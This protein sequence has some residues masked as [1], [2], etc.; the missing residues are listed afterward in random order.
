MKINYNDKRWLSIRIKAIKRDNFTCSNCTSTQNLQC[1]HTYYIPYRE[2]WEY[3]LQ[4]FQTLCVNC[5]SEYHRQVKGKDLVIRSNRLINLKLKE[6]RAIGFI[7]NKTK[8]TKVKKITKSKKPIIKKINETDRRIN[9][10]T[11]SLNKEEKKLQKRY[12]QVLRK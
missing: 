1:H 11:K 2:I 8:H 5:H 12:N 7:C 9:K 3:P 6:E 4:S 10:L